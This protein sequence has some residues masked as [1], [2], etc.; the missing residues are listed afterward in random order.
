MVEQQKLALE[1]L[2]QVSA[3]A[4]E[5]DAELA[6][7]YGTLAEAFAGDVRG[8]AYRRTFE[9][10]VG[11]LAGDEAPLDELRVV[12]DQLCQRGNFRSAWFA[13]RVAA[14]VAP[15]SAW[16]CE[17]A[18]HCARFVGDHAAAARYERIAAT[19]P[20]EN[21]PDLAGPWMSGAEAAAKRGA[22][23]DA[24]RA[25]AV[26]RA[27]ARTDDD[28][29]LQQVMALRLLR[30]RDPAAALDAGL[31]LHAE[32]ARDPQLLA[33]TVHGYVVVE[34][35]LEMLLAVGDRRALAVQQSLIDA[36]L[37]LWGECPSAWL[38]RHNLGTVHGQLGD[39]EQARVLIAAA[40]A[41]LEAQL[42][43]GHRHVEMA[44]RSL[45]RLDKA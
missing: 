34:L 19:L 28:R 30:A 21:D 33:E 18:G 35:V 3:W 22:H 23:G 25:L 10:L 15:A 7:C 13:A 2:E 4:D 17:V 8:A 43:R 12:I 20:D 32:L 9:R 44:R 40:L 37:A 29:R 42:G 39:L 6:R 24:E 11:Q 38:E 5:S 1:E 14:E 41:A 16:A 26:A 27:L 36:K 31:A 45:A